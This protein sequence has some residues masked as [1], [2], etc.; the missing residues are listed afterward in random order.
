MGRWFLGQG[1][2]CRGSRLVPTAANGC[3]AFGSYRPD[4]DGVHRPFAV[5]VIEISG[6]RIV[7]H[8]NFLDTNLFAAF[9]LPARL[10]A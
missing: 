1:V 6:G 8:H 4:A 3:A 7:G 5:Q 10:P 9:G 2:G